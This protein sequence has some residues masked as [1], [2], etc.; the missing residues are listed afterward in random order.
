M[1]FTFLLK[2]L[3]F[4]TL[5]YAIPNQVKIILV[6]PLIIFILTRDLKGKNNSNR[7]FTK[8]SDL[9]CRKFCTETV[10]ALILKKEKKID[11]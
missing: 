4:L 9:I 7:I 5:T 6:T 3:S 11:R 10:V 2:N 1:N 8:G